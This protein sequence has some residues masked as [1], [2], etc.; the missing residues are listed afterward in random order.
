M[1]EIG[2]FEKKGT[3]LLNMLDLFDPN[4]TETYMHTLKPIAVTV[5]GIFLVWRLMQYLLGGST[6]PMSEV[7][8]ELLIWSIVFIFAFDSTYVSMVSKG[9]NE[10]FNWVGGGE[11][12]FKN[13]DTWYKKLSIA[14]EKIYKMDESKYIK[15]QGAIAQ[16]II[17][18]GGLILVAIPFLII[19]AANML[20]EIIIMLA[21]FLILA[22]IFPTLK[23][24]FYN[25]LGLF[26]RVTLTMLIITIIQTSFVSKI[27]EFVTSAINAV[28][29][30]TK[31]DLI[32]SSILILIMCVVYGGLLI[33]AIPIAKVISGSIANINIG[34]KSL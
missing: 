19:I 26:L 11:E 25:G 32:G 34:S 27:N 28:E 29:E 3:M 8:T 23:T 12:F 22:L 7:F 30:G 33:S 20:I 15:F 24:M 17:M 14:G 10:V 21:P 16:L 1:E 6:K 4:V 31:V 13:L 2:F 18:L 5:L 9:M